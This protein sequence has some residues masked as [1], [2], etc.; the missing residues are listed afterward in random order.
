MSAT[1]DEERFVTIADVKDKLKKHIGNKVVIN[2]NLGRNKIEKY[3]AVIKELY[4]FVFIVELERE[5]KSFTY[6]DVITET[7][8]IKY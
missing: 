1:L 4:N 7:I 8:K 2:Y 3:E 5:I 6:A